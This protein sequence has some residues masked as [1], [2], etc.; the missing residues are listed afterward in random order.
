MTPEQITEGG[1]A[2]EAWM[3]MHRLFH[4]QKPR[5]LAIGQEFDLAPQQGLNPAICTTK[6]R[7]AATLTVT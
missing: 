1:V 3:L 6:Q 7:S 2:S 5:F 4:L